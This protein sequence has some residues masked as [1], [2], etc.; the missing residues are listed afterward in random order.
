MFGLPFVG[1]CFGVA[2]RSGCILCW[3][4]VYNV[5]FVLLF[6]CELV[7]LV[8]LLGLLYWCF[9]MVVLNWFVGYLL[10]W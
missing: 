5:C 8:V 9:G 4:I 1:D 7:G 6:G 2:S 10:R 3:G